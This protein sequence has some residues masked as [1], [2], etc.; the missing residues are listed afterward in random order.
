M[1]VINIYNIKKNI[2][3]LLRGESTNFIDPKDLKE[4]TSKLKKNDYKIYKPYTDASKVILYKDKIKDILL[5]EIKSDDK[6]KHQDI[7]GTMFS[8]DITNE[9]FGDI[10]V[11]NDRY[12]IFIVKDIEN[13]IKSNLLQIKNSKVELILR[14]IDYLKDYIQKYEEYEV[15]VS[16][17]RIDNVISKITN[18]NRKDIITK[19]KDKEIIVNYEIIKKPFYLLK[20]NDIFSIRKYGKYKFIGIIKNTKKDNYV[21]KY[22]KYV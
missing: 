21:I 22:L 11:D 19:I 6:L 3:K 18:L 1:K 15:I 14:D 20:E 16:S 7:L 13:Y 12:Y 8:L 17:L 4:I 9:M 10:I 5:Y 2:D